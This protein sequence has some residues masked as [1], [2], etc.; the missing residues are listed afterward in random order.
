MLKNI[1]RK[2]A[3]F[4]L[5]I[6]LIIGLIRRYQISSG[7]LSRRQPT[8]SGAFSLYSSIFMGVTFTVIYLLLASISHSELS[9]VKKI[10][11]ITLTLVIGIPLVYFSLLFIL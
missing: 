3:A 5:P 8:M 2:Y 6:F 11:S 1:K 10:I 7:E 9:K 4:I